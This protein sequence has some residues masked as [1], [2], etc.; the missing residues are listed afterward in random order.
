M[1]FE[2]DGRIRLVH[3]CIARGS[4]GGIPR[5]DSFYN[6][7]LDRAV[8]N[9]KF[10]IPT[11]EDPADKPFDPS[12]EFIFTGKEN[13]FEKLVELF[14][15]AD[16][17][18][19]SG[20]FAPVICEAAKAAKV[21]S[22]VEIMHLC[23]PGG[24]YP[25][26]NVSICVSNTVQKYQ[27]DISRTTVIHNGIDVGEFPF[28]VEPLP[29]DKIVILESSR[30]EK[31][32]HF[33]LDDLA[34][35]ILS[36][37]PRIEIW[38]AGRYQD[39]RSTDRVKFLGLV[40]DMPKLYREA[41]VM[42]LFSIVEPFGLVALEAMA[43]GALPI[44]SNDGGMA[45]I[46]TSGGDGWLVDGANKGAIIETV[47]K[48]VAM[49]GLPEWERMRRA[50]RNTVEIGFN[51]SDCVKK[52]EK[53]YIKLADKN[54]RRKTAGVI[55]V[56]Q[57]PP[58]VWVDEAVGLFNVRD[59]DN[60][61]A[62][63]SKIATPGIPFTNMAVARIASNI[64][65]RCADNGRDDIALLIYLAL[66]KSGIKEAGWMKHWVTLMDTGLFK[67]A[68]LDDLMTMEPASVDFVMLAAENKIGMGDMAGAID[69][70]AKGV[71]N[72][73]DSK[74]LAEVYAMLKSKLGA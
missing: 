6:R 17:V 16:I 19:F 22:I 2:N 3:C 56:P 23:E 57:P 45:E 67:G 46:V 8:F 50:A 11:E 5:M 7:F 61:A 20:G 53:I 60:L 34:Q 18:Q 35:E 54:G 27:P 37:D 48:A 41:D 73:P 25:E 52:Y 70:L 62:K 32:K 10:V 12:M 26:I 1:L 42:A 69:T 31:P 15:G 74:E 39:G 65:V 64:A 58:E 40:D 29:N 38:L 28:R 13:R 33:H 9:V 66:Y 68:V 55:Q 72:I 44:V 36:I 47:K 24:M 49:R 43:S 30:R 14:S 63:A 59:F 21:P 51:A 71:A 4:G